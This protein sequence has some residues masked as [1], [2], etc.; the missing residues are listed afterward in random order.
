ME[1]GEPLRVREDM[2]SDHAGRSDDRSSEG[3]RGGEIGSASACAV[4]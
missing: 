2:R 4:D 1:K 3:D